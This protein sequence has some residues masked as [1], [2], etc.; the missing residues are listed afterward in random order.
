[1]AIVSQKGSLSGIVDFELFFDDKALQLVGY[2]INNKDKKSKVDFTLQISKVE[3]EP[4]TL[5]NTTIPI[6]NRPDITIEKAPRGTVN[7]F[8]GIEW[9]I[10]REV[11]EASVIS[12]GIK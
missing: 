12:R 2:Q 11:P 3:V 10:K 6:A 5:N 8:R 7:V 4:E 9:E 1:M